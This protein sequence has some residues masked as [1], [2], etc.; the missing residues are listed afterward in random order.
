[1]KELWKRIKFELAFRA[2]WLI[3]TA[4]ACSVR[5]RVVGAE[6]FEGMRTSGEGGIIVI[7]HGVTVLPIF[8]CRHKGL[9]AIISTS[10]DG[11]LQNRLVQSRGYKTIRG[12]SGAHGV[13]AFLGAVKRI[14]DGAVIAVTPDGPRGPAK[15]VQHGSVLLAERAQCMVLPVGVACEPAKRLHSWDRHMIPMPFS[16]AVIVFGEPLRVGASETDE[17]RTQWAEVVAQ[18]IN[19]ADAEAERV[20]TGREKRNVPAV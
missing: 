13:R 9:W 7:W 1:L 15:V 8:F 17:E 4:I 2:L 6:R 3:S 12:S 19:D 18:A 10:K 14:Q 16:R 11:E 5:T 20:L